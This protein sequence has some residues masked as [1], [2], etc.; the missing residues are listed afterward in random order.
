MD[1]SMDA[2]GVRL[3]TETVAT[4]L[5]GG[6]AFETPVS[7]DFN[8]EAKEGRTFNLLES[9]DQ[10]LERTYRLKQYYVLDFGESVHGLARGA[11]VEF[12]GERVGEVMDIGLEFRSRT[13]EQL[14]RTLAQAEQLA[15]P[16]A[17]VQQDL[18]GMLQEAEQA[19]RSLRVLADYLESRP[20]AL[21]FGKGKEKP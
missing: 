2:N 20:N 13:M 7:L 1:F 10:V 18:R 14:Q 21:V 3:R 19:A 15:R 9:R 5:L 12:R 4:M 17:P 6:I 11:P 8:G 16:D